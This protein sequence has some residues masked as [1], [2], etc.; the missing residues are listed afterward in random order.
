MQNI[1]LTYL[2]DYV[3]ANTLIPNALPMEYNIINYMRSQY[4]N[5]ENIGNAFSDHGSGADLS[6]N[7]FAGQLGQWP[8]SVY[9]NGPNLAHESY[10][11]K[12]RISENSLYFGKPKVNK[13][14]YPIKITP[15]VDD[16]IANGVRFGKKLN[17]EFFWRNISAEALEDARQGRALIVIDY[18]L[19]NVVERSEFIQL[20]EALKHSMIPPDQIV[21]TLNGFNA[22]TVYENWFDQNERALTVQSWP[23]V[24]HCL[25][26]ALAMDQGSG[27]N[28]DLLM[29]TKNVLRTNYFLFKNRHGREHRK[30]LL[31]LLQQAQVLDKAD[32]SFLVKFQYSEAEQRHLSRRYQIN[33]DSISAQSACEQ[34]PRALRSEKHIS[35]NN[36]DPWH[37]SYKQPHF[38]SYFD[39]CTETFVDTEY[40]FLTEKI[41][42]PISSFQPFLFAA[43]PG[44]L[45]LLRELGFKT[46]APYINESYDNESHTG[47]RL[48]M[49]VDE[50]K[51]L[52]AMNK[53]EIHTWYWQMEEILIHNHEHLKR[54]Y[55]DEPMSQKIYE[56]LCS[57]T[58]NEL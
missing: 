28:I 15:H 8:L 54:I 18:V 42:K 57:K 26:Y 20:H 14:I 48:Q 21:L 37:Y 9:H 25:S 22:K 35:F 2:Y 24:M 40:K 53:E 51:R 39:V 13:Y 12:W 29:S 23:H 46:F 34:T 17:G 10:K 43:F 4:S 49:I 55:L 36:I 45:S 38:D 7:I 3:F 41:F 32:W 56:Y 52:C 31:W 44:A 50:V 47:T 33:F 1:K 11:S 27:P 58:S 30:I 6:N 5:K 16:F 19:E